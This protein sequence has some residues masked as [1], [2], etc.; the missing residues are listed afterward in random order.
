M[1]IGRSC[2]RGT[3]DQGLQATGMNT[4]EIKD[5]TTELLEQITAGIEINSYDSDAALFDKFMSHTLHIENFDLTADVI[6]LI[7]S[8]LK[9]KR[10]AAPVHPNDCMEAITW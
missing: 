4:L 7:M 6:D 9:A 10:D 5:E 1:T 8:H 3:A 2:R